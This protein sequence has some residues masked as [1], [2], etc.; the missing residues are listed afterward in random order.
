MLLTLRCVKQNSKWMSTTLNDSNGKKWK[1]QKIL[2]LPKQFG[3]C[4]NISM[5]RS[6]ETF[7]NINTYGRIFLFWQLYSAGKFG[8]SQLQ[9]FLSQIGWHSTWNNKFI[10]THLFPEPLLEIALHNCQILCALNS[11]VILFSVCTKIFSE[12]LLCLH[13]ISQNFIGKHE[14]LLKHVNTQGKMLQIRRLRNRL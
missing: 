1:W 2:T 12:L 8:A 9:F 3:Y 6:F 14:L 5:K 4:T 7:W 11:T 10:I 13:F